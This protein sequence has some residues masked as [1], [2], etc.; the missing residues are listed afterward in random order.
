MRLKIVFCI[1]I[2]FVSF[3]LSITTD[4]VKTTHSSAA[5][6]RTAAL[7]VFSSS[8]TTIM[9]FTK[10]QH[11][12]YPVNFDKKSVEN[13]LFI[14]KSRSPPSFL[15]SLMSEFNPWKLAGFPFLPFLLVPGCLPRHHLE[16]LSEQQRI[17]LICENVWN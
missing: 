11:H 1:F 2:I 4:W 12:P 3:L 9:H 6:R 5:S 8:F 10:L 7:S 17:T 14:K 13:N 16:L 15:P